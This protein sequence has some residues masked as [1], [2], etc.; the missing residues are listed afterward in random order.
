MRYDAGLGGQARNGEW[1]VLL[2]DQSVARDPRDPHRNDHIEITSTIATGMATASA[3]DEG[4][5]QYPALPQASTSATSSS[6]AQRKLKT[7]KQQ[8]QKLHN[9]QFPGLPSSSS[10]GSVVGGRINNN[11]PSVYGSVSS[12]GGSSS[13]SDLLGGWSHLVV[14]KK[15]SG[16]H[17]HRTKLSVS[18]PSIADAGRP[19][20]NA[21]EVVSN[22][23]STVPS[24]PAP[25]QK[26]PTLIP[27]QRFVC[28]DNVMVSYV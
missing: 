10:D 19:P 4:V 17:S 1:T 27:Y 23:L 7:T 20:S 18:K 15:L 25:M 5:D 6:T 2:S 14:N 26:Q 13:A 16:K 28:L 11:T 12:S 21:S 3:T 8:Q 22:G 24:N 9:N